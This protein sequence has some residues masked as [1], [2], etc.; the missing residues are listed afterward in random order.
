MKQ[1]R[2]QAQVPPVGRNKVI[3]PLKNAQ[4]AIVLS[5]VFCSFLIQAAPEKSQGSKVE[6]KCFVE[7]YGGK[8][9]IH[10]A[11]VSPQNVEG[12]AQQLQGKRV[13]TS[14]AKGKH[15]IYKVN[16]CVG[17]SEKFS[18]DRARQVDEGTVR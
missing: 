11:G 9:T 4:I 15:K 12:F 7:L 8:E 3:I 18:T 6:L 10:F 2:K 14:I 1:A 17:L 13:L 16:E 5:T